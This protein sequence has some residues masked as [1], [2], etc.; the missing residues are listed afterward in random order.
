MGYFVN[1][2]PLR[3]DLAG[4]PGFGELLARARRAALEALEHGD[5]PFPLLAERLR[6]ARDPARSPLFQAMLVLQ[7]RPR[8]RTI[9]ARRL[10]PGRGRG[11]AASSAA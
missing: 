4:E 1:P 3:A 8:P 11:A 2:L 9:R 10:R 6:P 5:F 7:Q